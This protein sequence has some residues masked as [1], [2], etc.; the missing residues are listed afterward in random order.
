MANF[1]GTKMN[2]PEEK[3]RYGGASGPVAYETL[4]ETDADGLRIESTTIES[5]GTEMPVYVAR[6]ANSKEVP[7]VLV[8]CEAFGL[9]EHI[10]DITRRFGH[11]G[12]LAI[13]P[14]L[15][16]RQGDALSF[17]KI[18]DL[19]RHLLLRIP[20]AQVMADLD[21]CVEWASRAGGDTTRLAA[22]GFCWGGRWT[23]LF[24]AHRAFSAAVAWYG[25]LDGRVNN[26]FPA[27]VTRFPSHPLERARDL[28]TPVLGL[29]AERDAAIPLQT[30]EH[31]SRGLAD[32]SAAARAS[33]IKVYPNVGHAFFADY[34]QSFDREAATDG[35]E[36]C[37]GWIARGFGEPARTT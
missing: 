29:Y 17:D 18:D 14:D 35:W 13:A 11:Q 6:P 27:D 25:V 19:L 28:K 23:W 21:A 8:I 1:K 34:R 3:S 10:K 9:N 33:Y 26:L 31:M 37:L 2:S 20:D 32:G 30:V 7:V 16:I 12:Y 5:R 22:T 36:R 4:I 15:M 24:A